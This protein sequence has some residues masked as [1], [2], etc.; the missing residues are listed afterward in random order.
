MNRLTKLSIGLIFLLMISIFTISCD[1]EYIDTTETTLNEETSESDIIESDMIESESIIYPHDEVVEV[2]IDISDTNYQDLIENALDEK[3]YS[4]DIT[5]N[6]YTLSNV[7]IRTKGNSS[8]RDVFNSGVDR[9]SYNIDLNYYENQDLFGIDKLILNNLFEDPTMMVEYFTYEALESLDVVSSRTTFV[10]LYING[11]YYGLYLS[12]EHVGNEFLDAYFGDSDG[13]MYK[14]EIG[15]GAN[16]NYLTDYTDYNALINKNSD[17]MSNENIIELMERIESG[18]NLDEIFNVESYLKYLA[19][20]TYTVNLDSY[21]GGMFHN[22]YLYNYDGVFQWITWDINMAFNGFPG[23]AMP[24]SKAV[25]YLIDEPVVNS[26]SSY[27][28]IETILA[29][30]TYL[31]LYH[32]YLQELITG[33]FDYATFEQRV[34]EVYEL[35]DEYV[36]NDTNSFYTYT[37]FQSA[38]LTSS[39]TSYSILQFVEERN[40]NVASQLSGDLPS[41]N[42]GLGNIVDGQKPNQPPRR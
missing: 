5:Y 3:Y 37:E 9:F 22:Y 11:I 21:Q 13:E 19:V 2:N 10:E 29:N 38:V 24:D 20:S 23:A 35:I 26:M 40:L 12:V 42:S 33:Y 25:Q 36:A 32:S 39:S 7:A 16:L 28:L 34:L 8:L 41:T 31:E 18:E 14:P 4:C 15:V 17:D 30:E 1:E 27:P 6:G